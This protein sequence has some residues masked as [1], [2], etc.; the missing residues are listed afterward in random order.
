MFKDL[1]KLGYDRSPSQA[2]GFYLA[3][4]LLLAAVA[5]LISGII[6]SFMP[7][8]KSAFDIGLKIGATIAVLSCLA[9][10]LMIL[11]E[12]KQLDNFSLILLSFLSGL[13]AI[14]IGG[15]GGLIPVAYLTTRKSKTNPIDHK[16]TKRHSQ[17]L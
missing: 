8:E 10:S 4:M 9:L 12:K 6:G 7:D 11:K 1:T 16:D 15:L 17:V 2:V 13:I 3:Y 5:A 14:F